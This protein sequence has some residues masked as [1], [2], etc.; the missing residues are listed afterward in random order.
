MATAGDIKTANTM[1]DEFVKNA[2]D[3]KVYTRRHNKKGTPEFR[4]AQWGV[5]V[6]SGRTA[7]KVRGKRLEGADSSINAMDHEHILDPVQSL[8]RAS[9]NVSERV[10]LREGIEFARE[11]FIKQFE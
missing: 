5:N 1:V 8:T 9:R 10:M 3:G 2:T 4:N 7:Q 6:T 11:K